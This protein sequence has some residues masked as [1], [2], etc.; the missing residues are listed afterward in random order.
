M[1]EY[2]ILVC[3]VCRKQ[4]SEDYELGGYCLDH[5][6]APAERV[7]V[8]LTPAAEP[9][10]QLG[11]FRYQELRRDGDWRYATNRYISSLSD[12]ERREYLGPTAYALDSIIRQ[13]HAEM[14]EDYNRSPFRWAEQE[15]S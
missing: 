5:M 10:L 15:T 3:P 7:E 1:S 6:D 4:V 13:S 2:R 12:A 8:V 14:I 11:A 9:A